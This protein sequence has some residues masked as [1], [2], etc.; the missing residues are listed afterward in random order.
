MDNKTKIKT[1]LN[2]ILRSYSSFFYNNDRIYIKHLT[3]NDLSEI[4]EET[5]KNYNLAISK[6]L[7]TTENKLIYLKKEGLWTDADEDGIKRLKGEIENNVLTISKLIK[8]VDIE[9]MKKIK[10]ENEIKLRD[11]EQKKINLIGATAET[12]SNKKINEFYIFISLFKD[13]I[14]KERFFKKDQFDELEDEDLNELTGLYFNKTNVF[15]GDNIKKIALLPNFLNLF[16]LCDNNPYYFYGKAIIELT[17]F[18]IELFADGIYFKHIISELGAGAQEY[19]DNPEK[20]IEYSNSSKN[21]K[22]LLEKLE[23][24]SQNPEP[25][26]VGI[27]GATKEDRKKLGIEG[28][29]IDFGAEAKKRGKTSLSM[30]EIMDITG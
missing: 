9:G 22:E 23:K 30:Q 16:Y 26:N 29:T 13:P 14:L 20:L 11:L 7:G 28:R 18:Q 21:A 2:D 12:F 4:D 19:M 5:E 1:G 27:V 6:G 17:L 25:I 10:L 3:N 15:S 24:D 8:K